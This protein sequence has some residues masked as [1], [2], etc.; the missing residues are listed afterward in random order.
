MAIGFAR[1]EF[2]SRSKGHNA[3]EQSAYYSHQTTFCKR[4]GKSYSVKSQ[5]THIHHEV[6]LPPHVDQVFA[7]A[8]VLWN[9]VEQKEKRNNSQLAMKV[10]L[11]LPNDIAVSAEHK[12]Q[13]ARDF[14]LSVFVAE[15]LGVQFDVHY[16]NVAG[17]NWFASLLVSTRRFDASTGVLSEKARDFMKLNYCGRTHH[18]N[19]IGFRWT[20]FQVEYFKKHRI[21]LDVNVSYDAPQTR[22]GPYRL[23]SKE[24][25][26]VWTELKQPPKAKG[27]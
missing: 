1:I 14:A 10:I 9:A 13:L 16:S 5:T 15:S 26:M 4:T 22:I 6:L 27:E 24:V 12:I 17:D 23:R 11:A 20:Q 25:S 19:Q 3:C 18:N 7:T 8:S 2:V 21:P